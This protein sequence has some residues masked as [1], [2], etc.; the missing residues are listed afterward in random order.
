MIESKITISIDILWSLLKTGGVCSL[1][2]RGTI[3]LITHSRQ[4]MLI[5]KNQLQ[6]YYWPKLSLLSWNHPIHNTTSKSPLIMITI[7][8]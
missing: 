1:S 5:R 8:Q 7:E 2:H 6:I 3:F 4:W